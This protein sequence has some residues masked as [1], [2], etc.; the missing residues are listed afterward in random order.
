MRRAGWQ[1]HPRLAPEIGRF[2]RGHLRDDA[3]MA[4]AIR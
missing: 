3:K 4:V 1:A 2:D